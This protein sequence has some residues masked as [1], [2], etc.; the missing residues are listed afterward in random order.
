MHARGSKQHRGIVIG[1]QGLALDLGMAFGLKKINVFGTKFL[2]IHKLLRMLS[3][4]IHPFQ[5]QMD[6]EKGPIMV[7]Y[8][9]NN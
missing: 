9:D 7:Q 1:D 5:R 4:E 6:Y 3:I 8:N 2:G